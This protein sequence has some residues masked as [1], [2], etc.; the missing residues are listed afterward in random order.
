MSDR[1]TALKNKLDESRA[2]LNR[3]LDAVGDRWDATVYGD[4]LQWNVRQLLAHL[5]DAERGHLGQ[6]SNIAEGNDIIPPDFDIQRYNRRTTEKTGDKTPQQSREELN[7]HRV[8]ML[9]WLDGVDEA[10]LDMRGRHASLNILSV[11]QILEVQANHERDHARDIA[12]A[13]SIEV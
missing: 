10:K 1:K 8:Q 7:A 12:K 11:E 3:V 5:A 13:L 4:G 2:Y 6:A 9:A